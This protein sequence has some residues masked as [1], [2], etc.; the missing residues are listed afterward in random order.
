MGEGE[1]KRAG[2]G[3]GMLGLA[4]AQLCINANEPSLALRVL[5]A[6]GLGDENVSS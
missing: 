4:E 1:R 3:K 6:L 5:M 2:W